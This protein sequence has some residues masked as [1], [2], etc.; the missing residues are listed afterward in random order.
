[1]LQ[2]YFSTRLNNLMLLKIWEKILPWVSLDAKTHLVFWPSTSYISVI[3]SSPWHKIM[4]LIAFP[5]HKYKCYDFQISWGI[6]RLYI[7][8]LGPL[9]VKRWQKSNQPRK[10]VKV[11][12]PIRLNAAAM[13]L[14]RR[15]MFASWRPKQ[16]PCPTIRMSTAGAAKAMVTIIISMDRL[17]TLITWVMS[18]L[19][20]CMLKGDFHTRFH[21]VFNLIECDMCQLASRKSINLHQT[22]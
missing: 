3:L 4:F 13:L 20:L 9:R 17:K 8:P 12:S 16:A 11:M 19:T 18:G 2:V 1:M 14:M 21:R 15:G 10:R 5:T 22:R 7:D 6:Y